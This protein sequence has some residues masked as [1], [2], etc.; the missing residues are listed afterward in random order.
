MRNPSQIVRDNT[1]TGL[2]VIIKS[3]SLKTSNRCLCGI[4][5]T[6]HVIHVFTVTFTTD[7]Q[8]CDRCPHSGERGRA[9]WSDWEGSS[10]ALGVNFQSSFCTWC[11]RRER[12]TYCVCHI[13][14]TWERGYV[15]CWKDVWRKAFEL[16]EYLEIAWEPNRVFCRPVW[17]MRNTCFL[18]FSPLFD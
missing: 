3:L 5:D 7:S 14:I 2:H 8:V 1:L 12:E 17:F 18:F 10:S 4:L 15:N 9:V 13:T 11:N 6:H 16:S